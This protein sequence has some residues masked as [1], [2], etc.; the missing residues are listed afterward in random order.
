[1]ILYGPPQKNCFLKIKHLPLYF[2]NLPTG[3]QVVVS[4]IQFLILSN[5]ALFLS[6]QA[7][8]IMVQASLN[9]R[10]PFSQLVFF[11]KKTQKRFKVKKN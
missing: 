6:F 10:I 3:R 7:Q 5:K 2:W 11:L 4:V 9:N 8:F 1:M